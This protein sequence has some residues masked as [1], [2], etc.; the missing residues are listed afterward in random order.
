[1]S[2]TS[3]FSA[4][5]KKLDKS[6]NILVLIRFNGFRRTNGHTRA[7]IGAFFGINDE[8]RVAFADGFNGALRNTGTAGKACIG[9]S[10]GHSILL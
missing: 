10:M 2:E 4:T 5:P 1:M 9:N 8:N 3:I 6:W 7:A